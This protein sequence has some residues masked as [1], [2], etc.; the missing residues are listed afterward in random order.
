MPTIRTT[1]KH[2]VYVVLS[3][4]QLT[5]AG[6]LDTSLENEDMLPCFGLLIKTGILIHI[7]SSTR[8]GQ[9]VLN[10]VIDY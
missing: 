10:P 5:N 4:M 7:I 3:L 1:T 8:L 2:A 9:V 6:A